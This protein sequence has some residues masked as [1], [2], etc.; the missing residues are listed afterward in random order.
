MKTKQ[1]NPRKTERKTLS[2]EYE[3]LNLQREFR[4]L[5]LNFCNGIT[6]PGLVFEILKVFKESNRKMYNLKKF[7]TALKSIDHLDLLS[8]RLIFSFLN[9]NY[10][11]HADSLILWDKKYYIEMVNS[12]M[13]D[14][15][16]QH[17]EYGNFIKVGPTKINAKSL[18]FDPMIYWFLNYGLNINTNDIISS[19]STNDVLI[20]K[21]TLLLDELILNIF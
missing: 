10:Q 2:P 16:T 1:K 4:R 14:L 6:M 5:K 13:L 19:L 15:S 17:I 9:K 12:I 3:T 21:K 7:H 18:V 20:G 11:N 8:E